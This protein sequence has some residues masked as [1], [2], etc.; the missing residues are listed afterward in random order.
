M[1]AMSNIFSSFIE[2]LNV[3]RN[4]TGLFLCPDKR[5]IGIAK[6]AA[7]PEIEFAQ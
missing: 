6:A 7:F 4:H 5:N 1:F 2:Q 3:A